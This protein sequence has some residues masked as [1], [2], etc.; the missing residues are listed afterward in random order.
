MKK[1]AVLLVE[2][3]RNSEGLR[4]AAGLSLLDDK[5]DV[6]LID[7]DFP[8]QDL[9]VIEKHLKMI[10]AVGIGLYSN[11]QKDGF[12]FISTGD[13]GRKLPEYDYVFPY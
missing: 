8:E 3:E 11:F 10:R 6:F 7:R 4:M 9:P 2:N 1:I 12:D 13:L 5:V